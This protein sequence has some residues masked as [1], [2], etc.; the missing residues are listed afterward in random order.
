MTTVAKT[1]LAGE[2]AVKL[3]PHAGD[4]HHKARR[5]LAVQSVGFKVDLEPNA[6]GF[7]KKARERLNTIRT[8]TVDVRP[9]IDTAGFGRRAQARIDA[10]RNLKMTVDL[11]TDTGKASAELAAWRAKQ[12]KMP[13][14]IPVEV[15]TAGASAQLAAFRQTQ[16][17]IPIRIRVD[18]DTAG[19]AGRLAMLRAGGSMGG[20]R[21]RGRPLYQ[22][23]RSAAMVGGTVMAPIAT[24]ATVGGLAAVSGAAANAGAAI[25]LL[26]AAITAAGAAFGALGVG[27]FGVAGAF[28]ALSKQ[29][30]AAADAT[31][32][33]REIANAARQVESAE[34]GVTRAERQLARAHEDVARAQADLNDE[35]K[36][37]VRRL[38]DMNDELRLAPLNER[39]AALAIREAQRELAEAFASGDSM[40]IE[41]AKINL[42][43]AKIDYDILIKKNQDLYNDT[44]AA[45]K[46]GVE[47]DAQV[48]Q[49]KLAVRDA[50][51]AVADAQVGVVEAQESLTAAIEAQT[52]ALTGNKE[53]ADEVA[54]A[55]AKLAPSAREFV[56]AMQAL[57]PQWKELRMA[58]QER[59]FARLG[60]DVTTL[61]NAQLPVLQAGLAGVATMLNRGIRDS[62]EVFS[63]TS[64][65]D[66]F[67]T[68]L[69]NTQL[70][71]AGLADTARP[72]SQ[73]WID[74]A[75][76][77]STFLPRFGQWAAT[78]AQEFQTWIGEMRASGELEQN[79]NQALETLKQFGRVLSNLGHILGDVFQAGE[80]TGYGMLNTWEQATAS[81]RA[82]T[83]SVEG[84]DA[85]KRF[86]QGVSEA[87]AAL[88]PILTIIAKTIL[89][90][91]GPALTDLVIGFGPGLVA[92]F[93]GLRTGLQAIAP[94]MEPLGRVVGAVF[95][96]LGRVFE[97]L[98]PVIAQTIDALMPAIQPLAVVLAEIIKGLAPILPLLGQLVGQVISA[99]APAFLTLVNALQP[100]IQMLVDALMPL[101]PI[102]ADALGMLAGA[103]ADALVMAIELLAPYLPML[104]DAF[105]RIIQAMLPLIPVI[106]E[107]AMS[108]L[109]SL[110]R[111]LEGILPVVIRVINIFA[112]M[113]NWIVPVLIPVI[114]LLGD[115]VS[116]VF[117]WIGSFIGA[118]FRNVIDPTLSFLGKAIRVLGTIF[119]W[120]WNEVVKPV[121]GWLG[122]R[123]EHVYKTYIAPTFGALNS[124]VE[125]VGSIFSDIVKG[126]GVE[127]DKLRDL[128]A[129]PINWVIDVVINGAL[130]DAW[131]A[132]AAIL[133]GIDEW[134]GVPRVEFRANGGYIA[135][136]GGPKDDRIPAMLSNGEYVLQASAVKR[137]GVGT[138]NR[139]NHGAELPED[140][141]IQ[142][143]AN[144][145]IVQPGVE[146][147]SDIQRVMWDAVRAA[148]PNVVLTSG[149]RYADVGSGYDNHMAARALDLGGPMSQVANWIYD[150]N[151]TQP[152]EE[153]I[154]W[155]LAG[156]DNL[157]SGSPLNY[158]SPT[159]E[160]HMDH[161]HWAMTN[162]LATDGRLVS[163][164]AGNSGGG[165]GLFQRARNA[166]A[167]KLE[168]P[169]RAAIDGLPDWGPS[170]LSQLP[171]TWMNHVLDKALE[172]VRGKS[173]SLGG[174]SGGSFASDVA[175]GTGPAA[176]QVKQVFSEW[177]WG[178]GDQWAATDWIVGKESSWNPMAVNPSSGAFGLFQ[179]NPSSGTLQEYLPDRNPNPAVQA[180][181]GRRYIRDRYGDPVGART[182][183][184]ANG[185][186]DQGGI[187]NGT[188]M[189]A[190]NTIEPERVLSPQQT[191]AFEAL[192]PFLQ[193]LLPGLQALQGNDPMAVN[194]EQLNG[195][196][197]TGRDMP[198]T[199]DVE[200]R[201]VTTGEAYG[202]P[203][204]G[205]AIDNET[206]EYLPA[207]NDPTVG[208][209]SLAATAPKW[210]DS[211]EW[212][213]GKSIAGVFG[214]GKQASKIEE[215]GKVLDALGTAA[216]D[217]IPA[218][219]AAASGDPSQLAARIAESTTAWGT[220][221]AS[222]FANFVP[223][224]AGGILESVLSGIGA[225]L[226]GTVNTG[227]SKDQVMTVLEDANNRK[228]RRTKTGRRR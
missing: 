27:L 80:E 124:A 76:V 218:W 159:N 182:F 173:D 119:N 20:G 168:K 215:K 24:Q 116:E 59:L 67:N 61:A 170:K 224:N 105:T 21:D 187:A 97:V 206:G 36:L 79:F 48:V 197:L 117:S 46:A 113:V 166:I 23:A 176:D 109:P 210:Y 132:L 183:W 181:A 62:I 162:M 179:F 165:G 184:E 163:M 205:A 194:V 135:G 211:R 83:E 220:K 185:C 55:M 139:L 212:K 87:T 180:E 203:L 47:G 128:A 141:P 4:F 44:M 49:A 112:D 30:E 95:A 66:D 193:F 63:S 56:Y 216:K 151:A 178:E 123:I 86:F 177:G 138:L 7:S 228:A 43:R 108:L 134:E 204:Q 167:D 120:L 188:G 68:T 70:M 130:K 153:L 217:A 100:V 89:D 53:A 31:D 161:V 152:V 214:F 200:G 158:G 16:Q 73:A 172:F 114:R 198:V 81:L 33:T 72:L 115:I 107:V 201:N 137:L 57:G 157:K 142:R 169:M 6:T 41:G 98:G 102:L 22:R 160:Q 42:D 209:Y 192:V 65:V 75:T 154:H 148:F 131:N 106:L 12:S 104:F 19:A 94:L 122:D 136:P 226:I 74:L 8:L 50:N 18:V 121:W 90:T 190:K 186:Y 222:D 164:D 99:V 199:A 25:G 144:G 28:Q 171:K 37:A 111:A 147:T 93:E 189:M 2:A 126:I 9:E 149:T 17:M 155:P 191:A 145:G 118:V 35:R 196:D 195:K 221:T 101:V 15:L 45:N 133:P 91:I 11:R 219:I 54:K 208:D 13:V 174:S 52:D 140:G 202:Q 69:G 14:R 129:I 51:D 125:L 60:E 5:D 223:E 3:I 84:Q 39:E 92:G 156:W 103:I 64:A 29:S 1:Y 71:W 77:G 213:T 10:M 143:Y 85:L 78:N 150:L 127:W 82:F 227:L 88:M 38:R 146:I 110:M 225:P 96:E 32:N 40:E 26:P 207:N 34:R 58:T 175:P